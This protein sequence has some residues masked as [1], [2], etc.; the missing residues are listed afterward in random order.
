MDDVD[1]DIQPMGCRDGITSTALQIQSRSR[2]GKADFAANADHIQQ[3]VKAVNG[4][5]ELHFFH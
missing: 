5:L 2:I 3:L 1:V 4:R